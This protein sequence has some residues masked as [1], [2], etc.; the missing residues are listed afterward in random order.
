MMSL[1]EGARQ[2]GIDL[3][4]RQVAAFERYRTD[5]LDWNQRFNLTAITDPDEI[6]GKHFLDSL[7]CLAALPRI[8]RRPAAR[9]LEEPLRAVDVGAGAGF[10]G[11][12]LKIVWPELR[13]TLLEA[14]GK[15]CRFLEHVVAGLGLE[16]V[17]VV[18]A[19]AEDFGQG[20]GRE[21][22]DLALARAVTRLPALLEYALPLL[23]V[24]GWLIAQ[25]GR[26]PGDELVTARVALE[27]LGG[28]FHDSMPVSVPGLDAER[29]LVI[30]AKAAPTPAAYPRQAGTPKRQPI[31]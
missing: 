13:L 1:R 11:L 19:R 10:P 14:T 26:D 23:R 30:I 22:F 8:D 15:K 29:N 3:S 17:T 20:A 25:K 21:A 18:N 9:W 31:L 12:P 27:T 6:D 16:H 7:S 5:L 4:D 28:S 24:G 2:L